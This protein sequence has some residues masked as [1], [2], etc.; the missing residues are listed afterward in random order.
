MATNTGNWF[1]NQKEV[2]DKINKRAVSYSSA[3]GAIDPKVS[4]AV[5]STPVD[6]ITLAINPDV[7]H[8]ITIK[9]LS[10]TGDNLVLTP[11][12][13]NDGTTVTFDA[14]DEWCQLQSSGAVW[15]VIATNATVA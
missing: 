11:E 2:S 15:F 3:D 13:F 5:I 1:E 12:S 4:L 14:D 7:G 10:G 6:A 9:S 8:I